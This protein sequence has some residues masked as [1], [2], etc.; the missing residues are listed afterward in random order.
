MMAIAFAMGLWLGAYADGTV[1]PMAHGIAFWAVCT[2]LS[3][4]LL[5]RRYGGPRV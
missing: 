4:W 2:A 5:V 1:F 3:A